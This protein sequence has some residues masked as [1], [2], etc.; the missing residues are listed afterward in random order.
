[1]AELS[2]DHVLCQLSLTENLPDLEKFQEGWVT[3]EAHSGP[4][5]AGGQDP[6]TTARSPSRWQVRLCFMVPAALS[7]V[8][9]NADRCDE[10]LKN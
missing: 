3:A 2:L 9:P 6:P 1:M 4:R 8:C 10:L 7:P 5:G